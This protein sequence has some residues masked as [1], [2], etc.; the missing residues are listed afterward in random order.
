MPDSFKYL[1]ILRQIKTSYLIQNVTSLLAQ[2]HFKNL[3]IINV[4]YPKSCEKT[5]VHTVVTAFKK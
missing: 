5:E 4:N 1:G 3:Q 2:Q